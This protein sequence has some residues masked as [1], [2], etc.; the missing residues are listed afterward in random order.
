MIS[1]NFPANLKYDF[2]GKRLKFLFFEGSFESNIYYKLF[3][4]LHV[5]KPKGYSIKLL[6]IYE[7]KINKINNLFLFYLLNNK[8]FSLGFLRGLFMYNNDI[9]I[10]K[11]NKLT[12]RITK[13][14]QK[15]NYIKLSLKRF[16][17][18][19]LSLAKRKKLSHLFFLLYRYYVAKSF[20]VLHRKRVNLLGMLM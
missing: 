13:V 10:H 11:K 14:K 5:K 6:K 9:I 8:Q 4:K 7:P 16:S 17:I 18:N 20:S 12:L 2:I 19:R 15:I 1:S 3:K